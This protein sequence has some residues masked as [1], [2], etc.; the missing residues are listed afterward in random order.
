MRKP[1]I[2]VAVG[3]ATVDYLYTVPAHP[4]EDS[5]NRVLETL[6]VVGGPAGRGAI[7]ARRLGAETRLLATIGADAHADILRAQL[8]DEGVD[9]LWVTHDLPS[10]HSAVI[11][12]REHSTRT[13]LWLPQPP[14]DSR[15][16]DALPALL[17]GA[18]AVLMDMTDRL[19]AEAVLRECSRRGVP[20]VVD[21]GSRKPWAEELLLEWRPAFPVA[22]A[23]FFDNDRELT[24][25]IV[26]SRARW[27]VATLGAT[28]GSEGGVWVDG[29]G[30]HAF[31]AA[32]VEAIDTCGAGDTF[33][34]ALAWAVAAGLS[35]HAAFDVARWS[36]GLK[37]TAIGNDAI[38]TWEQLARHLGPQA[39]GGHLTESKI[40]SHFGQTPHISTPL[41]EG[42]DD[43][44]GIG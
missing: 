36:A 2:V 24:E 12:S 25:Q 44:S 37:T 7:A 31:L 27:G 38:P 26:E 35:T 9:C 4:I 11:V 13:T 29:E 14:H 42:A 3:M 10:Q 1:P 32:P 17:D 43:E 41:G 6:T 21:T 5:E 30:V 20:V 33:H 23:K 40:T 22:P 34:G 39:P 8:K 16:E 15:V 18:D 28:R 19:V